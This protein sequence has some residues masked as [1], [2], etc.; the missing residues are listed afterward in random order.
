M[1]VTRVAAVFVI[2]AALSACGSGHPATEPLGHRTTTPPTLSSVRSYLRNSAS[3]VFSRLPKQAGMPVDA[4]RAEAVALHLKRNA[5]AAKGVSAT[6]VR[7]GNEPVWIV[8][9]PNQQV[10]ITYP[11]GK[12]GPPS[13]WATTATL[14]DARTG[15]YL[16]AAEVPTR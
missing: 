9:V 15:K 10:P 14:V 13:Y 12:S 6:L 3:I 4:R 8:L 16:E 1:S 7:V 11:Y 2:A 5:P